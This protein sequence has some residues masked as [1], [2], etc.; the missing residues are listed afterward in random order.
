MKWKGPKHDGITQSILNRFLG[1]DP[2]RLYLYFG[3]GLE[4]FS[5]TEPNLMY[6]SAAHV[7]LEHIIEKPYTLPDFTP[8]D[9]ADVHGAVDDCLNNDFPECP[10]TFSHSIKRLLELYDDSFKDEYGRFMTEVPFSVPYTTGHG[11]DITLRG[12]ID[13]L[14]IIEGGTK[15]DT[16]KLTDHDL[17][18]LIEG[19]APGSTI[20]EHKFK[21]KIDPMGARVEI[22][23]DLQV[24]MYCYASGAREVIYD[25]IRIPDTQYSLPPKRQYQKTK[26]YIDELYDS[27]KWGDFPVSQRKHLWFS[28]LPIPITQQNIDDTFHFTLD[29]V[30]DWIVRWYEHCSD[31]NFDYQNPKYY[32]HIFYKKPIRLFDAARTMTFKGNYYGHMTNQLDIDDLIPVKSFYAELPE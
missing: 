31:P 18:H 20:G 24:A 25:N 10:P 32:N 22:P 2:Y 13:A 5:E 4:E 14:Q 6:G 27:R 9:W 29:P 17:R 1:E 23:V 30:V 26:S 3:L 16:C 7:G 28:Q 8:E 21:G 15:S 19:Y 11:H 12:K